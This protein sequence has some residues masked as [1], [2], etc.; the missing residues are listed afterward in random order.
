MHSSPLLGIVGGYGP[1]TSAVFCS[2]L[3]AY[4]QEIT[5]THAPSF[6]MDS[7]PISFDDAGLCISGDIDATRRLVQLA[8]VGFERLG[9]LGVQ[10]VALPCNSVHAMADEFAI[11]KSIEFLHI[12]DVCSAK[13]ERLGYRSIGMMA[14]DITFA[15]GFYQERFEKAGIRVAKPEARLQQELNYAIAAFVRDGDITEDAELAVEEL[16]TSFEDAHLDAVALCC[17]DISGLLEKIGLESRI[18]F[19]DSMDALAE[20]CAKRSVIT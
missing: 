19:V 11:P 17:T 20:A 8:N 2:R 4:A 5:R 10:S 3:V 12:G 6:I 1:A 9:R 7:I 16:M 13:I 18:P 14:S 15:A